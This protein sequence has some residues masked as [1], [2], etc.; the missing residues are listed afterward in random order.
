MEASNKENKI[1]AK[2]VSSSTNI[3]ITKAKVNIFITCIIVLAICFCL[4]IFL[5]VMQKWEY[6]TIE[7]SAQTDEY[8]RNIDPVKY[9]IYSDA[10]EKIAYKMVPN[11]T[12]NLNE[13]G[14]QGWELVSTFIE[15]ETT[16]P[17][18]G[19]DDYVSGLQP[20]VRPN[21]LVCIFKRRKILSIGNFQTEDPKKDN[22]SN[23]DSGKIP[24]ATEQAIDSS[25]QVYTEDFEVSESTSSIGPMVDINDFIINILDNNET[26]YLK[27][28]ITIELDSEETAAEVNQRMAQ[29]RDAILVIIGKK[30]FTELSD[31][32]GKLKLRSEI[33]KRLNKILTSGKV[34][35]IYFTEFV[36]Q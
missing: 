21:K 12:P 17:N 33:I 9:L 14:M 30:T 22:T 4:Q 25:G 13:L 23:I 29:I 7:I 24:I 3:H 36:I 10:F 27:A 2:N 16:H 19:D 34:E 26:R 11:F 32:Q 28:A 20:N 6:K 8:M 18:Y 1:A 15:L 5:K 35:G 31:L